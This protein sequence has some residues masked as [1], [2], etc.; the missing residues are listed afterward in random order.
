LV[1]LVPL[2]DLVLAASVILVEVFWILLYL[3][4]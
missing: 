1:G 2:M 4:V 3:F